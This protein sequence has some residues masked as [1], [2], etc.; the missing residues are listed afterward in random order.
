MNN[1]CFIRCCNAFVS[2]RTSD[3]CKLGRVGRF[4]NQAQQPHLISL[5]NR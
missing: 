4:P 5:T 1:D 3:V 2:G